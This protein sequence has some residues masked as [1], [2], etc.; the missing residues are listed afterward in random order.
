MSLKENGSANRAD[1]TLFKTR[2]RHLKKP[3]SDFRYFAFGLRL[4]L[5][6]ESR[7]FFPAQVLA[8]TFN[9]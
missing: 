9:L 6:F 7:Y 1:K 3:R 4:P 5:P 8:V 2:E